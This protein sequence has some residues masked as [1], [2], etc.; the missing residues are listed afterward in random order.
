MKIARTATS[1]A[2]IAAAVAATPASALA[3][4]FEGRIV[5]VNPAAKTFRIN[6]AQR[7]TKKIKVNASTRFH[8]IAGF[9]ALKAGQRR[10]EVTAHRSSGRWVA[11]L[12]ERSGG[13]GHHG[14]GGADD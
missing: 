14:G 4:Q 11:S 7:G 10:I 1:L 9:S 3:G 13:G 6:D 12:V 8:R 5:S 2:L